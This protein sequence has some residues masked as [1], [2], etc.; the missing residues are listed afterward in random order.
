VIP[1]P[2]LGEIPSF[3][4]HAADRSLRRAETRDAIAARA[5]ALAESGIGAGVV[6]PVH[7]R[8]SADAVVELLAARA[9][10]AIALP[11]AAPALPWRPL[12]VPPGVAW[13]IATSGTTGAP[14]I[15][16]LT[17]DGAAFV[18]TRTAS[19]LGLGSADALLCAVPWFH[20][21]GLSQ[22]WLS[23]AT[24]A[25]FVLPPAPLLPADL[26]TWCARATVLAAV[27]FH[28][29][30]I[31]AAAEHGALGSLR[32]ITLA[33]Q[34][35]LP[36]DRAVL[37][38]ALPSVD[39][40]VFYGL[41]EATS[42]V[43]ALPPAEFARRPSA[44]G[45]PLQGIDARLSPRGEL[46]VRGPNVAP[47]EIA[48]ARA[49]LTRDGWLRTGDRFVR[50]GDVYAFRGRIDRA[51][52]RLGQWVHPEAVE[53][54]LREIEGVRDAHVR[55]E[56]RERGEPELLARV[57]AP[58]LDV[59]ALRRACKRTLPAAEVPSAIEIVGALE[60]TAAGKL[61]R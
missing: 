38:G 3:P 9:C 4:I 25:A 61:R 2:R 37:H 58:D 24:G 10:G 59:S 7:A 50:E 56:N 42:R 40:H 28:V 11:V 18:T 16:A 13:A 29:E 54:A 1:R 55:A 35:T 33:G 22:L 48:G 47:G 57:V 39:K 36:A 5:R 14:R 6:V 43:L 26:R 30:A 15:V 60:R 31:A 8:A 17:A 20:S 51:L 19:I 12:R 52:K 21:Y 44:T 45:V 27:P 23:A 32:A 46:Q 53:A 41:T 49:R 34:S